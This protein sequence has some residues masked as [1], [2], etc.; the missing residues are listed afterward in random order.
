MCIPRV[1]IR[2]NLIKEKHNGALSGHFGIT[3][4]QDL[5]SR[6]YYCTRMNLDVRRYVESCVICQKD[7]GT[8]TNVGLYQRL[9][10]PTRLWEC[11]CR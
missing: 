9:P 7:K 11:G 8:S 5:V 4:I 6:F 2:E 1:S 10:I 3:K